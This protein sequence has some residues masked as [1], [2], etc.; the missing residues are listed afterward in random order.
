MALHI[1]C[2]VLIEL[3][4]QNEFDEFTVEMNHQLPLIIFVPLPYFII[5]TGWEHTVVL[6]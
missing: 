2:D 5:L 1:I 4:V 3:I 6:A